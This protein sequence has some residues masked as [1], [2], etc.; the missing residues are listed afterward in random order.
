MV[1]RLTY[2]VVLV[3]KALGRALRHS[4]L[5]IRRRRAPFAV[6]GAAVDFFIFATHLQ[7]RRVLLDAGQE[8]LHERVGRLGR[9][10]RRR[11][12]ERAIQFVL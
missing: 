1:A 6:D 4:F 12:G 11:V 10:P 7:A 3:P 2:T 8:L 9:A 5:A